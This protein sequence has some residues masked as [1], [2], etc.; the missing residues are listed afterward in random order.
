[1]KYLVIAVVFLTSA[2]VNANGLTVNKAQAPLMEPVH[3]IDYSYYP[4]SE[5]VNLTIPENFQYIN[6]TKLKYHIETGEYRSYSEQYWGV[7]KRYYGWDCHNILKHFKVKI[8]FSGDD[9]SFF[10]ISVCQNLIAPMTHLDYKYMMEKMS[11]IILY[12]VVN[13]NVKE[14]YHVRDIN[15]PQY[16]KYQL[17]AR[18]AEFYAVFKD[19]MPLTPEDHEIIVAYFDEIFMGNPFH[20]QQLRQQCDVNDPTRIATSINKINGNRDNGQTGIGTN[21]CGSWSFNMVNSALAYSIATNNDKLFKQAKMNLTHLLG[22][23]DNNGIQVSQSSRG[24]VAWGYHTDV[25]IQLGYTTEI[26]ASIG[27]DFLQHTMP[28][29]GI[30]VK[31]VMDMHWAIIDDHTLLGVYSKYNKGIGKR[32]EWNDIK[33][34]STVKVTQVRQQQKHWRQIALS[35]P[36]YLNEY[37]SENTTIWGKEVNLKEIANSKS[38]GSNN[39]YTQTFPSEYLYRINQSR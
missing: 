7:E 21:G 32:D 37:R 4:D 15:N 34:L 17:M 13:R 30:K 14:P 27:Y 26:L 6:P 12:H 10:K 22:S 9:E 35:N 8:D 33:H 29:S 31:D 28:R 3:K 23:F 20:T 5:F 2:C 25:T 24:G 38:G 39:W 36:R 16:A 18:T 11:D 1:M 19:L